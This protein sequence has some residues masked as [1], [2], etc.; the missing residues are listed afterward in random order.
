MAYIVSASEKTNSIASDTETKA[1]L[2]LMNFHKDKDDICFFV[3]DFFND[4]TGVDRTG[5][6]AWD[7]QSKGENG[8]SPRNVGAFLVTLFKNYL[9]EFKFSD[10]ILFIGSISNN[11]LIDANLNIFDINNF[12]PKAKDKL[13]NGLIEEAQ[14]KTYIDKTKVTA[15][16]IDKFLPLV[17]FVTDKFTKSEYIRAI[18]KSN[19]TV[20]EDYLIKIFNQIRDAQSAK[21]NTKSVEGI[22]IN[23]LRDFIN[24]RR[25]LSANEIQLMIYSRIINMELTKNPKIPIYFEPVIKSLDEESYSPIDKQ[26]LLIQ[27]QNNIFRM[28]F[29]KNNADA[30]WDL[31]SEIFNLL[32]NTD[33]KNLNVE[34]LYD[35]IDVDKLNAVPQLDF[36]STMYLIALMK[37]IYND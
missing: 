32:K 5:T 34:D 31:F 15:E 17:T 29:N 12:T 8:A 37:E 22:S 9:S 33:N 16:N 23:K 3:V 20:K 6:K 36:H 7:V 25:H 4:I 13:R 10:F 28:I 1:M 27:C 2:H 26:E 21:K 35:K 11:S 24:Y 19:I 18:I 14:K 30:Y